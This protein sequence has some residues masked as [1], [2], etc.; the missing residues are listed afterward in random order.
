MSE[1]VRLKIVLKQTE[2]SI[3]RR[4]ELPSATNF[5][6]LHLVIQA[7][8]G[9]ENTHLYQFAIGRQMFVGPGS[10]GASWG[11]SPGMAAGRA[12]LSDMTELGIKRF[13]YLY[14]MGDSWDHDL[15]IEKVL[16]AD[17][18][19]LYPKLIDGWGR[20]PPEDIGGVPGFYAFLLALKDPEDP[21]H[22]AL[23]EWHGGPFDD[24]AMDEAAIRKRLARIAA[25]NQRKAA[26][27]GSA[28]KSANGG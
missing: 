12:R 6:A 24:A 13:A 27:A 3:W 2:P 28:K 21:E 15:R 18:A 25:R 19:A 5:S 22:D 7:A 8:M 14:D 16:P 23:L 10:G 26:K 17:P 11:T 4:I 1:I 20:C 9:W